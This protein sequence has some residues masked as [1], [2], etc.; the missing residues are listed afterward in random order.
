MEL[1][2]VDPI[3]RVVRHRDA[4]AYGIDAALA[5]RL[6]L[7]WAADQVDRAK[8]CARVRGSSIPRAESQRRERLGEQRAPLP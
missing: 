1:L 2:D 5:F 6:L 4:V 8:A 7:A 3:S